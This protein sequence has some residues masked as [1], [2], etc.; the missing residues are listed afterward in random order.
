MNLNLLSFMNDESKGAGLK[1]LALTF[2]EVFNCLA[3]LNPAFFE[4]NEVFNYGY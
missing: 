1:K 2:K 4:F 3:Y